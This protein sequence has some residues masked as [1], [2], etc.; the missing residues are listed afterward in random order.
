MANQETMVKAALS[1]GVIFTVWAILQARGNA[2][3]NNIGG[4]T[5]VVEGG[6][7][8]FSFPGQHIPD[9]TYPYKNANPGVYNYRYQ[10]PNFEN[11][12]NLTVNTFG[13]NGLANQYMPLFGLVGIA[14]VRNTGPQEVPNYSRPVPAS[15][16]VPTNNNSGGLAS[17]M[18]SYRR[19]A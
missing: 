11:T 12:N 17:L 5:T 8:E 16:N 13:L 1:I 4:A 2:T 18:D 19:S 3:V 15:Y 7:E 10:G 6:E 14:A 9:F